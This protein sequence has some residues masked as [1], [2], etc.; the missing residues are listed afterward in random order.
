MSVPAVEAGEEIE[1]LSGPDNQ[2][3]TWL[4]HKPCEDMHGGHWYC[5]TCKSGYDNQFEMNSNT[6]KR[7]KH[8]LV[9]IC[10]AHGP[11]TGRQLWQ[12]TD[13]PPARSRV[14]GFLRPA[15]YKGA[16]QLEE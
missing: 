14:G 12:L 7:R 5:V 8:R 9:W 6:M 15:G 16:G 2:P 4:V 3:V 11:G 1:L 13:Q 10:H